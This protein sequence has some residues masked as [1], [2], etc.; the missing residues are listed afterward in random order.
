MENCEM[1]IRVS[2]AQVPV[3]RDIES[4]VMNIERAMGYAISQNSDILLTPE[5][6]LSGYT[7]EFD[8][9]AAQDA[10]DY[11]TQ[12]AREANLGLA[13]GTCFVE[14]QDQKCYNQ[15]RFYKQD[16]EYL[17]F[18][19]KTLTCGSLTEPPKGETNHYAISP[20]ET[21]DYNGILIGG[22]ICNDLWANPECTPIPDP[23]LTQQLSRMGARIIFHAV[24]GG[25]SE[26][27]WSDVAWR[28]HE[29]NLR[30]RARAGS[31]W[32]V[33]VDNCHPVDIRCSSPS[34][35]INPQGEWVCR[36]GPKGEQFFSCIIEV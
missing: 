15:I 20:L 36:T 8:T 18:H 23:H 29:S 14:P 33:T 5:G 24:N 21:F 3:T 19:S 31:L 2:G 34:G 9:Q 6:S 26:S 22:L 13:L 35:V 16:G 10:L 28:Y 27:E 30:M 11:V 1:V 12:K 32:I 25:R 4:N 17:G 7:H